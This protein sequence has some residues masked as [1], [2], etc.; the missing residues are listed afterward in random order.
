MLHMNAWMQNM[1]SS[2]RDLELWLVMIWFESQHLSRRKYFYCIFRC[3]CACFGVG[4]ST[5]LNILQLPVF[6]HLAQ[7]PSN[8]NSTT[9][10]CDNVTAVSQWNITTAVVFLLAYL[11]KN[12]H[13]K[14][15]NSTFMFN[16]DFGHFSRH[17]IWKRE[18]KQPHFELHYK[19]DKKR[20]RRSVLCI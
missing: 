12:Y 6:W 5:I 3:S 15:V 2:L 20:R 18:K 4:I 13:N 19:I 10:K 1:H 8:C 9:L 7:K 14:S 11:Y 16:N 17:I